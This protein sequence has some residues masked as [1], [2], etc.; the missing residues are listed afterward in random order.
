MPRTVRWEGAQ[1]TLSKLYLEIFWITL[2]KNEWGRAK[3]EELVTRRRPS[4]DPT[5]PLGWVT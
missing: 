1:A 5:P 4:D 2:S 3:P